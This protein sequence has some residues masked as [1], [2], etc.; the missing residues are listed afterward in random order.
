MKR[1]LDRQIRSEVHNHLFVFSNK[2]LGYMDEPDFWHKANTNYTLACAAHYSSTFDIDEQISIDE[3]VSR[4]RLLLSKVTYE[5]Y[6]AMLKSMDHM[7]NM[8]EWILKATKEA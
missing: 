6:I 2:L 5:E 1:E 3:H 4:F 7:K 8:N